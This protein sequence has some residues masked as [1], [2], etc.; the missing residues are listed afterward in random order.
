MHLF[1][2]INSVAGWS[3]G[4]AETALVPIAILLEFLNQK[5][6]GW[7]SLEMSALS[8]FMERIE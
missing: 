4:G 1:C 5:S 6:R 7:T 8:Y 2:W 3:D